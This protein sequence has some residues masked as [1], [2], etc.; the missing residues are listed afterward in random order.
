M[1]VRG[2]KGSRRRPPRQDRR[3]ANRPRRD[4]PSRT[5]PSIAGMARN[6]AASVQTA[7]SAGHTT[8][9]GACGGAC[10]HRWFDRREC[11]AG[12]RDIGRGT[13]RSIMWRSSFLT[14]AGA[15][16]DN[17]RRFRC[18]SG[19]VA[20]ATRGTRAAGRSGEAHGHFRDGLAVVCNWATEPST[21]LEVELLDAE[22]AVALRVVQRR[23]GARGGVP[24]GRADRRAGRPRSGVS[25]GAADRPTR[26]ARCSGMTPCRRRPAMA[27]PKRA[28]RS[29]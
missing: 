15:D 10:R 26:G 8:C 13:G 2:V 5:S 23:V 22:G 19:N 20:A 24:A 17:W 25:F 18:F 7:A 4:A 21:R 12:R 1:V 29:G 3:T 11:A 6:I 16:T 9:D 14:A 28:S 27:L